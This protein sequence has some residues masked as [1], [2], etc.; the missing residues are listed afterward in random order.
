MNIRPL[1][2]SWQFSSLP[3]EQK[4]TGDSGAPPAS[5]EFTWQGEVWTLHVQPPVN[6]VQKHQGHKAEKPASRV[7][8]LSEDEITPLTRAKDGSILVDEETGT[9]VYCGASAKRFLENTSVFNQETEVILP[10]GNNTTIHL[11]HMRFSPS[12]DHGAILLGPGAKAWIEC[13]KGDPVVVTTERHPAWYTRYEAQGEMTEMFEQMAAMTRNLLT[14]S[15]YRN[16]FKPEQL[17]TLLSFGV[18]RPSEHDNRFVTWSPFK[19][20]EEIETKLIEC[21]FKGK[22]ISELD[23]LWERTIR[24]KLLGLQ[25]GRFQKS[26]FSKETLR[27]LVDAGITKDFGDREP[28]AHWRNIYSEKELRG[29]LSGAG[30]TGD[31]MEHIVKVWKGTTTSGYDTSGL[32]WSKGKIAAYSLKEKTNLWND[33]T[34]EWLVNSTEYGGENGA[35]CVGVSNI[36]AAHPSAEPTPFT[37]LRPMESLHRHPRM[38][39]KKQTEVYLVRSGKG[40]LVSMRKGVPHLTFM[41]E[42]DMAVIRPD[43]PHCVLAMKDNYEHICMQVPSAFQYGLM[44]KDT[45][46]YESFGVSKQ[47]LLDA[48]FRGL[49][50]GKAGTIPLAELQK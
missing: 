19:T 26:D 3:G 13:E 32:V 34:T 14:C 23:A 22:E 11:D 9:R 41:N 50:E 27:K 28:L 18:V 35:F 6:R 47:A 42:G 7:F 33:E 46:S 5:D 30:I 37:E 40:V 16:R 17:Q 4:V 12:N 29:K 43:V 45:Q 36:T 39:E 31:E 2:D 8:S 25:N 24:R 10:E 21:G 15:T 48:A 20:H 38:G 44:F 1:G 49:N